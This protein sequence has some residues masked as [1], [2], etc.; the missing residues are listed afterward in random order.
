MLYFPYCGIFITR[1]H[2][3]E[4]SRDPLSVWFFFLPFLVVQD[5]ASPKLTLI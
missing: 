5:K 2:T 1:N 4:L 3:D